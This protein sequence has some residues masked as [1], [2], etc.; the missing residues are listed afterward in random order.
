MKIPI[1]I[2]LPVVAAVFLVNF[3]HA[4]QTANGK[5][6]VKMLKEQADRVDFVQI[7]EFLFNDKGIAFYKEKV[8]TASKDSVTPFRVK[9][10]QQYLLAGKTAEAIKEIEGILRE[11]ASASKKLYYGIELHHLLF[12]AYFRMGEQQNCIYNNNPETCIYPVQAEGVYKKQEYTRIA[13]K[14][15]EGLIDQYPNDLLG[16]WL[17]NLGYMNLGLYPTKTTTVRQ[18]RQNPQHEPPLLD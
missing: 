13:I 14:M 8:K 1:K 2:L 15:L 7:G 12:L 9:L 3:C 18:I 4:Q 16:K 17:F 6:I 11:D 5:K 10:S